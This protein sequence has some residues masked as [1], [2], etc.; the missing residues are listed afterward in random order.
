MSR[1]KRCKDI[2]I[3]RAVKTQN[4]KRAEHYASQEIEEA[5]YKSANRQVTRGNPTGPIPDAY[6]DIHVS[7]W[8]ERHQ[9]WKLSWRT[10]WPN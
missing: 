6:D 9:K 4:A 3:F 2:G 10:G 8:D 5:G 1:T 7:A